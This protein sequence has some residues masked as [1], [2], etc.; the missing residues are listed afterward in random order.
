M[1]EPKRNQSLNF[2]L[3]NY[4]FPLM[5]KESK[6]DHVEEG[7]VFEDLN[8]PSPEVGDPNIQPAPELSSERSNQ[9]LHF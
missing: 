6:V 9:G 5:K 7:L 3:Q 8:T 1:A 4:K 2:A